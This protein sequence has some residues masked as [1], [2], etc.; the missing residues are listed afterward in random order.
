MTGRTRVA[1][2]AVSALLVLGSSLALRFD[3]SLTV[4]RVLIVSAP[5]PID[6]E[7][8]S[9]APRAAAWLAGR[10]PSGWPELVIDVERSRGGLELRAPGACPLT[11][12]AHDD[13]SAASLGP[14]FTLRGED[15]Q[16]GF[17]A[18]FEL[19]LEPRCAEAETARID[20]R[21]TGGKP[22]RALTIS[23]GGRRVRGRTPTFAE[24][25]P[26]PIP[27]GVVPLSPRT[28]GELEFEVAWSAEDRVARRVRVAAAARATGIP[29]VPP[30]QRLLLGGEGWRVTE[31]VAGSRADV[32]AATPGQPAS[33]EPDAVGRWVLED[34]AGHSLAVQVGR[35]AQLRLDCGRPEC[36]A[37]ATTAA[38]ESPMTTFLARALRGELG[39]DYAPDCAVACH[40]VG[41]P[42]LADGGFDNIARALGYLLPHR[43]RPG[44]WEELPRALRRLSG[45]GCTAC[46]GPAAIPE[47]ES[48]SAI[49]RSDV[50]AT[51]HDAPPR[52]GH[53]EA[54][55]KSRMAAP[56]AGVPADARS[57]CASCHGVVGFLARQGVRE[58][59]PPREPLG[60]TCPACHAPHGAT[61][62]HALL[63]RVALPRR[64]DALDPQDDAP[65]RLCVACH[66]PLGD[67]PWPAQSAALLWLGDGSESAPHR[68]VPGGCV[69][70][71]MRGARAARPDGGGHSFRARGEVCVGCHADGPP[72]ER[73]SPAGSIAARARGL[74]DRLDGSGAPSTP[75]HARALPA[76][77]PGS[78]PLD[79]AARNVRLVLED[80]AAWVHNGPLARAWLDEAE[81]ALDAAEAEAR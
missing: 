59:S 55:R 52:Y 20:W 30:G 80:P 23:E 66:G 25:H 2:L 1:T 10:N 6:L 76:T 57:G 77:N 15:P 45:V 4:R 38:A 70:C 50:C 39:A 35:H 46:H 37:A 65:A 60:I 24:A 29:I 67:E 44:L 19:T 74:W 69:G 49:L 47:P 61:S 28:R 8:L 33:F 58:A 5:P 12:S 27:W 17:D 14:W 75:P 81:R 22:V 64:F 3:A 18:A 7:R 54:W 72:K 21:Q 43:P 53:V 26:E 34:A 16:R 9:W 41:E 40:A 13:V 78:S 71:H 63:R 42:G 32:L 68:S 36:H 31:R 11:V 48:R 79:R 62:G 56:R 51:C 73:Q